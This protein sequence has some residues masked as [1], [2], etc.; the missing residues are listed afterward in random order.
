MEIHR[1]VFA[2]ANDCSSCIMYKKKYWDATRAELEEKYKGRIE[3]VI[4][5]FETKRNL[6]IDTTQYPADLRRFIRWFPTFILIHGKTWELASPQSTTSSSGESTGSTLNTV[7]RL[8]GVIY[9]GTFVNDMAKQQ[10][11]I[12]PPNAKHLIPWI[13][14][15]LM[16]PTF[17][18]DIPVVGAQSFNQSTQTTASSAANAASS[19]NSIQIIRMV[20]VNSNHSV[21]RINSHLTLSP[22]SNTE[23]STTSLSQNEPVALDQPR[24]LVPLY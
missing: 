23:T 4:I 11:N 18:R 1:L 10:N 9:Y 21:T 6:Q 3:L 8:E 15:S 2:T 22:V 13:E 20:P 7:K 12:P 14:T 17:T 19:N 24:N 5:N 16:T